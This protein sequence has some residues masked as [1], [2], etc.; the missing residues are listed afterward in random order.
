MDLGARV[1]SRAREGRFAAG[2]AGGKRCLQR[3]NPWGYGFA[4]APASE[5]GRYNA[6]AKNSGT[7]GE[8][9]A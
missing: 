2:R 7:F 4:K 5:G 9:S 3:A 8:E 6:G 1:L